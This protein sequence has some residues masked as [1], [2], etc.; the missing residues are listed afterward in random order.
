MADL[1]IV[2][3]ENGSLVG[4]AIGFGFSTVLVK[5]GTM[6]ITPA[7]ALFGSI[8]LAVTPLAGYTMFGI[9]ETGTRLSRFRQ[10]FLFDPNSISLDT[11]TYIHIAANCKSA[12]QVYKIAMRNTSGTWAIGANALSD[13]D[14]NNWTSWYT[15]TNNPH[16][17]EVD[18]KASSAPGADDGFISLLID[19]LLKEEKTGIDNDTKR[20]GFPGIGCCQV[21]PTGYAGT[22][23]LDYWRGNS[24]GS[25][26]ETTPLY[27]SGSIGAINSRTV[28]IIFSCPVHAADYATGIT[29]K[30]NG[31]TQTI[32]SATRQAETNIVRYEL[33]IGLFTA[34]TITFEYNAGVGGYYDATDTYAMGNI[35]AKTLVNTIVN[36]LSLEVPIELLTLGGTSL[37]AS[38]VTE[39]RAS[40]YFDISNYDG[41]PTCY[42]EVVG[43]NKNASN[44]YNITLRDVTNS[45]D[46]IACSLPAAGSLGTRVRSAAFTPNAGNNKLVVVIDQT[47]A[48]NDLDL[49]T[50]R[51]VVVQTAATKTRLQFPLLISYTQEVDGAT[52]AIDTTASASYAQ[53]LLENYRYFNKMAS[54][55]GGVLAGWTLEGTMRGSAAG[56][57][58]SIG[59]YNLTTGNLVTGAEISVTGTAIDFATASFANNAANFIDDDDFEVRIKSSS[60]TAQFCSANLYLTIT[61]LS[62]AEVHWMIGRSR[63]PGTGAAN[64]VQCRAMITTANYTN[65]IVYWEAVGYCEDDAV[66]I[67]CKDGG[68]NDTGTTS[69][70]AATHNWN[71]ATKARY[72]SGS[73]VPTSGHRFFTNFA[74][75][76]ADQACSGSFIA[77]KAEC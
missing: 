3:F 59:L 33:A 20:V 37:S 76:T 54:S 18:W 16:S 10:A 62:K 27:L 67:T 50:A 68:T 52:A 2:T 32:S 6:E 31:V 38:A 75:S 22:Y 19:G 63:A 4:P 77:I 15:I 58:G 40:V 42:F 8:G 13:A 7:A 47:E 46:L 35:S 21:P 64:R 60:G 45:G 74:A 53:T 28:E 29:I 57:S 69:T 12:E 34:D 39:S 71:S 36:V 5:G 17:I 11:G 61:N 41:T 72:R 66:V 43:Y 55:W 49:F 23:Y 70:D 24:D 9:C 1:F 73:F 25:L 56:Q 26:M 51:I 30:A 48:N 65:P 44:A 14:A